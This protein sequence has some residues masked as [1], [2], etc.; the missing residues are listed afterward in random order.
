MTS[1]IEGKVASA[2]TNM[3]QKDSLQAFQWGLKKAASRARELAAA[4]GD[5]KRS[6]PSL[7]TGFVE[8]ITQA[9]GAA[10]QLIHHFRNPGWMVLRDNLSLIKDKCVGMAVKATD[11][12]A[13]PAWMQ[14]AKVLDAL[15]HNGTILA[16]RKPMTQLE[17]E[18]GT[19][20][21]KERMATRH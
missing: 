14:V 5:N 11:A 12:V 21:I 2:S 18:I 15:L 3:T 13:I 20:R 19:D 6:I 7:L 1:F 16:N 8:G 10:G 17:V 9:E 4:Y